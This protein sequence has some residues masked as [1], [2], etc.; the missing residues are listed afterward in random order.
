MTFFLPNFI[1]KGIFQHIVSRMTSYTSDTRFDQLASLSKGE[2]ENCVFANCRFVSADFSGFVFIDCSFSDCD[3]SLVMLN[4]T[5]FRGVKFHNCKMLGLR[6]DAANDFG[7]SFAFDS[8]QLNHSSYYKL[9][10]KKTIFKNCQLLDADFSEC[11]LTNS[12]FDSCNLAQAQF[13]NS[14]LEKVDFRSA[15]NYTIDPARNRITKARF[16][17]SGLPGLLTTFDLVI[18]D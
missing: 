18:E 8:C 4:N 6:F 15:I 13:D 14:N 17:L 3:L 16:S 9:R 12:V 1:I 2:Y 5:A 7:L 11:D 10:L